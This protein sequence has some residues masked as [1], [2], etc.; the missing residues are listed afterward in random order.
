MRAKRFCGGIALIVTSFAVA[1]AALADAPCN[2]GYRDTT[3]A[4]RARITAVLQAAK[5]ALPP[6]PAGWTLV[7]PDDFSVWTSLCRDHEGTPWSYHFGRSYTQ[8]GDSAEREKLMKD[9][10]ASAAAVRAKNQARMDALQAEM[11][12]VMQQQMALNQKGD[13][14]GAQKLQPQMEKAQAEYEKLINA[15][16]QVIESAGKEFE[17]DL[18]M[19]ISVHVN[20]GT[21][22]PG[23]NA[24]K[25]PLPAGA[26]TALRW[27]AEDPDA[28][29]DHAL[30]MFGPWKQ[31]TD[32]IWRQGVRA[33]VPPSGS[34]AVS[35]QVTADRE[36]L[37]KIVQSIDFGKIAA[38]V[39]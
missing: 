6:A 14:D 16:S 3:P 19:T 9:A 37:A 11:Q 31:G 4:E 34:H 21:E 32:G 10:A 26:L 18:H 17:R 35:V 28:T 38:T 1:P 36:R 13:Y 24:T 29:D 27:Q 30:Y 39:K 5:D 2:K 22:R 20:P 8:V 7:G 25:L 33:G 12:K 23:R 15:Q